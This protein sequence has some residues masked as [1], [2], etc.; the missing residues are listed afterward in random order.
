[1]WMF[2]NK[3]MT[4]QIKICCLLLIL[5]IGIAGFFGGSKMAAAVGISGLMWTNLYIWH[6]RSR[7]QGV[8]SLTEQMDLILHGEEAMNL[9]HFREGDL[10]ILRDEI[11]KILVR[12][13]EQTNL[14]RKEKHMLADSLADISH[15][16]RTPLTALHILMV[17]LKSADLEQ[18]K[19]RI[20]IR[21]AEQMLDKIEWLVTTLLKMSKLD[22]G[23]IELQCEQIQLEEFLKEAMK[24]FEIPLEV[25]GKEYEIHCDSDISFYADYAWTL[26]AVQNV[27]KNGI[28]HTPDGGKIFISC[29]ENPLYAEITLIDSGKGIEESDL[30][31]LFERFYRG[32]NSGENSFGIGLS[33]SRMILTRENA[34]ITA[35]NAKNGGGQ[36]QIRF[37]K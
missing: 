36:F 27:I 13:K 8:R 20:M 1:M 15:Q 11:A 31:H 18:S 12:L 25:H 9:E 4:G 37:Y 6:E 35:K 19:R 2:R 23:A 16:I 21:E 10:E 7:Y 14:L 29:T 3:G 34:V 24:P 26:E 5:S 30:P 17:R 33:L 28:E 22:A 32:K